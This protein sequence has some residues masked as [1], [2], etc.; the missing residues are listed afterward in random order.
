MT[1][2]VSVDGFNALP[3]AEATQRL[4][5]CLSAPAGPRRWLQRG[6]TPTSPR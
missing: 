3:E 5:T 4:L 2:D 6:R 1:G